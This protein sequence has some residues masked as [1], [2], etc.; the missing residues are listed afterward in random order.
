[1][2]SSERPR[3]R[4]E[5]DGPGLVY[6]CG[7]T[8]PR[9]AQYSD[10][11][12]PSLAL[13]SVKALCPPC[14]ADVAAYLVATVL[15]WERGPPD[16]CALSG[17]S[18]NSTRTSLGQPGVFLTDLYAQQRTYTQTF[19]RRY[20]CAVLYECTT[21]CYGT[22]RVTIRLAITSTRSKSL[23]LIS[24][25]EAI[26]D[27]LQLMFPSRFAGFHCMRI[28]GTGGKLVNSVCCR[29]NPSLL[30]FPG[31]LCKRDQPT[32]KRVRVGFFPLHQ[33]SND[34]ATMLSG[35]IEGYTSA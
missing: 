32:V 8:F 14:A 30:R 9:D 2:T 23:I 17:K 11:W 27:T 19:Q 1:M 10:E 33:K 13:V 15:A 35:K 4:L 16:Y 3:R 21:R 24:T 7:P 34:N 22:S 12:R 5:E 26:V 20:F 18:S 25:Q 31:I 29:T 28:H 6:F